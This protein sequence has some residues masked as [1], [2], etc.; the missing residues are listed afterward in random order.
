MGSLREGRIC[1]EKG[2][3]MP[4]CDPHLPRRCGNHTLMVVPRRDGD[5]SL[6]GPKSI[7]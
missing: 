7:T 3:V 6:V 4:W 1:S 2:R 5:P